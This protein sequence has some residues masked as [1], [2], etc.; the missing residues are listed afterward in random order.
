MEKKLFKKGV[1]LVELLIS[2]LILNLLVTS[3]YYFIVFYQ[4]DNLK[5][6]EIINDYVITNEIY[7]L[8]SNDPTNFKKNLNEF[9]EGLWKEDN[10]YLKNFSNMYIN[11]QENVESMNVKIYK[12]NEVYKQWYRKKLT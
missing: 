2:F 3:L 7:I 8:F 1:T 6:V 12:N 4:K 5:K 10:Y 11:I 9:Y